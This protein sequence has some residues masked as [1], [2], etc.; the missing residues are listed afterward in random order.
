MEGDRKSRFLCIFPF[1][2]SVPFV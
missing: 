1:V 2:L